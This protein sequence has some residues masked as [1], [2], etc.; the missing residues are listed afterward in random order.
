MRPRVYLVMP[1]ALRLRPFRSR[2]PICISRFWIEKARRKRQKRCV[3]LIAKTY[4]PR[5]KPQLRNCY[6]PSQ[7]RT[8][9]WLARLRGGLFTPAA[10]PPQGA[11]QA[12]KLPGPAFQ[13]PRICRLHRFNFISHESAHTRLRVLDGI[14]RLFTLASHSCDT[15]YDYMHSRDRSSDRYSTPPHSYMGTAEHGQC[16]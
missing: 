12:L 15:C 5:L 7:P 4:G 2:R 14:L 9:I 3:L 6:A 13:C 8:L 1:R 11:L 16:L 10:D